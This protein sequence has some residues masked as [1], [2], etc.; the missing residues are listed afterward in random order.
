[1]LGEVVV[2]TGEELFEIADPLGVAGGV[3]AEFGDRVLLGVDQVASLPQFLGQLFDP[4]Q[5]RVAGSVH[6]RGAGVP[7]SLGGVDVDGR[8]TF[9]VGGQAC[10][11]QRVVGR[12]EACLFDL[13][14]RQ[15]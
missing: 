7:G 12:V 10:T 13:G 9:A 2:L 14:Q 11:V 8:D 15:I 1:F 3:R 5:I 4:P 6:P